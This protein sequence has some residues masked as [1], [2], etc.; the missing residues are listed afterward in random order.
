VTSDTDSDSSVD[1]EDSDAYSDSEKN[2][3]NM[4]LLTNVNWG[5]VVL[6]EAH[7][8]RNRKTRRFK[9]IVGLNADFRWCLTGTAIQ[10]RLSDLFSL[11]LFLENF[12]FAYDRCT[13]CKCSNKTL[14][15]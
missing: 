1:N 14:M 6:D 7:R 4:I 9:S 15:F 2:T 5:R 8:I 10:N 3:R 12:S 13:T 11:V